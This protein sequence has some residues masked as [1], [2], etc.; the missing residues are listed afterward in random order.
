MEVSSFITDR[1]RLAILAVE[2][3]LVAGWIGGI[4][5]SK[6]AWEL[7]PLV[8]RPERQRQGLGKM[9][10]SAFEIRARA[11]GVITVWLGTDDDFGGTN[12]FGQ[13]LYPNVL[14]ALQQMRETN[15]HP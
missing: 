12:L 1:D 9:L 14:G 4:R 11:E 2:D 10:V 13:D 6:F 5:H 15:G 3:A 7:H 8:V